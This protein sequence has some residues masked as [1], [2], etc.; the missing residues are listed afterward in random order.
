M[1]SVKKTTWIVKK[2]GIEITRV[3]TKRQAERI[4]ELINA[5]GEHC[6]SYHAYTV[7][8]VA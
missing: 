4:V 6:G 5:G 1:K 7:E 3:S 8:W 2:D